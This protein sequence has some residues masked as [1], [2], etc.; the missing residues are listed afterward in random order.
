MLKAMP[1][2]HQ[3]VEGATVKFDKIWRWHPRDNEELLVGRWAGRSNKGTTWGE[4][5]VFKVCGD[6]PARIA[7][8]KGPVGKLGDPTVGTNLE[9]AT[10]AVETKTDKGNVTLS[11]WYGSVKIEDPPFVKPGSSLPD[12]DGVKMPVR[13][14][15]LRPKK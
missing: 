4:L 9:R 11:Y 10:S 13:L 2:D 3:T 6:A 5:V 14:P 12:D 7:S 8:M 15:V 1:K